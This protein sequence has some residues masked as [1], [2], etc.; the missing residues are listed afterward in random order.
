[1]VDKLEDHVSEF[2]QGMV[3]NK[4]L[5]SQ[6][7]E[8]II[9]FSENYIQLQTQNRNFNSSQ[10]PFKDTYFSTAFQSAFASYLNRSVKDHT[11]AEILGRSTEKI[12]RKGIQAYSE[13][14]IKDYIEN[15][16]NLFTYMEDKDLFI[17]VYRW[18]L[19]RRL[20]DN[21]IGSF[22]YEREFIGRIKMSCGPQYTRKIEGMLSDSNAEIDFI[23]EFQKSNECGDIFIDFDL[24]VLTDGYW[25]SF[26][27]P[28]IILPKEMS[29]W[30]DVF[31]KYY[32]NK[33][34]MKHLSWSYMHGTCHVK[35]IFNAKEYNLILTTYQ[36]SIIVL[37]NEAEELSFT[38]I[39]ETL[40]T[41]EGLL[42]NMLKSL[43]CRRYKILVKTGDQKVVLGDDVFKVNEN[44]KNKL[45][46]ITIPAPMIKETFNKEKVD[47]DRTHAIGN[48]KI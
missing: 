21:K 15:I 16:T 23:N 36:T 25:P 20:L 44:F 33:N 11:M 14:Q 47:I 37:F 8:E 3:I 1:M 19:A 38:Q 28:P 2:D 32:T 31:N 13:V 46:V 18:G 39:W 5:E 35:S 29:Q 40:K 17:D 7:V 30:V 10:M 43:S 4:I 12:M 22:E 42:K 45:K 41:E 48:K 9:S 24:K 27:S 26:K 6:F 34:K